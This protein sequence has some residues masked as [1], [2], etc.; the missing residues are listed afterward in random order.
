MYPFAKTAE[1]AERHHCRQAQQQLTASVGPEQHVQRSTL[2]GQL[3]A[4][5]HLSIINKQNFDTTH[6]GSHPTADSAC[7][8]DTSIAIHSHLALSIERNADVIHSYGYVRTAL[9]QGC[10]GSSCSL[11]QTK[12]ARRGPGA[13]AYGAAHCGMTG[14]SLL[15]E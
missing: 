15:A 13:M 9:T 5:E 2:D 14:C 7:L 11:R 4:V 6:S 3:G 10:R 12:T 8:L 1:Y